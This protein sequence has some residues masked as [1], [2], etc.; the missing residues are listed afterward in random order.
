M[1]ITYQVMVWCMVITYSYT[2]QAQILTSSRQNYFNKYAAKL[3]TAITELDKAFTAVEGAKVKINF[4]DFSF[5]GMVTSSVRRY[6]NLFSVI[7]KDPGLDNT[8]LAISKRINP[9]KTVSYT[10]HILN[11]KYA[12]GFELR[13]DSNGNYAMNKI[14]TDALIEDY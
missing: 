3:P 8:I 1:K 6:N 11:Q 13:K 14:K 4:G 9:D 7:V 12:D 10:A 5:N 2:T